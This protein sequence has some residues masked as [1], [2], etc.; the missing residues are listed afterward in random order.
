MGWGRCRLEKLAGLSASE[1]AESQLGQDLGQVGRKMGQDH[2]GRL[3]R[4][5]PRP[6]VV[7]DKRQQEA[8]DGGPIKRAELRSHL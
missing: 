5:A 4:G 2:R 8:K 1:V 7:R 6:Q 3:A